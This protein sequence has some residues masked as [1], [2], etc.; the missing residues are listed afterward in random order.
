MLAHLFTFAFSVLL[1][2]VVPVLSFLTA[3]QPQIRRIPPLDLYASAAISQWILTVLAV[4]LVLLDGSGLAS[5]GLRPLASEAFLKWTAGLTLGTL[6][7]LT[8]MM[9]LESRG[10][11]PPDSDLVEILIP[12][13]RREKLIALMLVAP[14]AAVC[15]EILYRGFLFQR[16]LQWSGSASW[17]LVVAS[18]GF[19]LAHTYQGFHG[20]VR[21]AVLGA[22]LTVP[23][24]RTES[25][26][27]SL[28]AHFLID[29]V[30]LV[31]LGPKFL[32][33]PPPEA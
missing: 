2:F 26:F 17:A 19:G 11:W 29:A 21:A 5:L 18:L 12:R 27:P 14:T 13:T 1:L 28:A 6:A 25:L 3:R 8:L 24:V 7:G 10:L 30:A 20:M 33:P 16:L 23:L 22:L 15:E 9:V 31:W 32:K 4:G